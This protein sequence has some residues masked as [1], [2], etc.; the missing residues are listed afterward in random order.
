MIKSSIHSVVLLSL[1]RSCKF[2]N[3]FNLDKQKLET[4]LKLFPVFMRSGEFMKNIHEKFRKFELDDKEYSLYTTIL[5]ISAA[6]KYLKQFE[7]ISEIR[8]ELGEAL[9]KYMKGNN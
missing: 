2:Y 8:H 5:I 3:Y 6:N 4:Y 9:R 1:Q 7:K